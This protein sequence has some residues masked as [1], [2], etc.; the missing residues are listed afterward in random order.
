MLRASTRIVPPPARIVTEA[1][2][3]IDRN[4]SGVLRVSDV[5]RHLRSRHEY[6]IM[7]AKRK[8]ESCHVRR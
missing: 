1:L 7:S 3:F 4:A 6:A 5:V 8:K 2:S